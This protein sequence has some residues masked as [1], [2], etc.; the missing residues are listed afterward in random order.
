VAGAYIGG[1]LYAEA[2]PWEAIGAA[3]MIEIITLP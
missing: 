1:E 2:E 3:H